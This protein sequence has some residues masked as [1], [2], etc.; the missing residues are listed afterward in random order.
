MTVNES[1][2]LLPWI[3]ALVIV[4]I[5]SQTFPNVEIAFRKIASLL[6]VHDDIQCIRQA[7]PHVAAHPLTNG[8]A[9]FVS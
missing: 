6:S 4:D 9:F 5:M 1:A 3:L 8:V 7:G 2:E